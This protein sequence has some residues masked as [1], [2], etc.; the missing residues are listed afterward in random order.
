MNGPDVQIIISHAGADFDA[1]AS[2]VAA[3]RLYPQARLFFVGSPE[4]NVREFVTLHREFF[5]VGSESEA[6]GC[7]ID[8]IVVVDTR[9]PARLGSFAHAVSIPDIEV[10]IY[11]HH[12][13]TRE[14][15]VGD[16]EIVEPVGACITV[17]LKLLRSRQI[18]ISPIEATLY[19]I[20]LYEETGAMTYS[21]TTAEDVSAVAWLLQK[22]ANLSMVPHFAQRH[23]DEEQRTLLGTLLAQSQTKMVSGFKIVTAWA[24]K[25]SY[26][27]DMAV[28]AQRVMEFE[29]PDV[30]FCVVQMGQSRVHIAARSV[31]N[32]ADVGSIM[33]EFLCG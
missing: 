18:E 25:D 21:S 31:A 26:V 1:F 15:I 16:C 19:L 6:G 32:S 27:D 2:M 33:R 7:G 30:L 4:P 17:L 8:H 11:D 12:P 23:L 3:G 9:E 10:H 20:A 5:D 28:I 13:P 24:V 29:R 22:K 14:S